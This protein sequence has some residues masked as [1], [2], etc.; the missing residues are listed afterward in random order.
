MSRCSAG[1]YAGIMHIGSTVVV[2]KER[3]MRKGRLR[4]RKSLNGIGCVDT[5]VCYSCV[6][7]LDT[8]SIEV[9]VNGE[10]V[11]TKNSRQGCDSEVRSAI[12]MRAFV[13]RQLYVV[14]DWSTFRVFQPA[15][16]EWG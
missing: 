9:S 4:L 14:I 7:Y 6:L 3:A 5:V 1:L 11:Q 12:N 2:I 10:T 13:E 15:G 8:V 16:S